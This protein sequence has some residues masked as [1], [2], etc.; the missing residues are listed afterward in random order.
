MLANGS[1]LVTFVSHAH[2]SYF[3]HWCMKL[4]KTISCLR[5]HIE[6]SHNEGLFSCYLCKEQFQH[7][8]SL[9]EHKKMC[10]LNCEVP[11]CSVKHKSKSACTLHFKRHLK[12]ACIEKLKSQLK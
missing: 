7:R 9:I 4:E 8:A 11:Q 5:S 3:C 2:I 12:D 6:L 10:Q 1:E